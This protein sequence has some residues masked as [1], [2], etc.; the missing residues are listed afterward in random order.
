MPPGSSN[1][2]PIFRPKMSFPHPFSDLPLK[3]IS[4]FQSGGLTYFSLGK[5][6]SSYQEP[7]TLK[8]ISKSHITLTLFLIHLELKRKIRSCT[9][10][11]PWKT[12]PVIPDQNRQSLYNV[13]VFRS[14]G[15]RII[16]FSYLEAQY[17]SAPCDILCLRKRRKTLLYISTVNSNF[18]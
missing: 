1:P 16:P 3:Y 5:I 14:N 9:L 4:V 18:C 11:V 10:V 6:L 12:T 17:F 15:A 13:L 2:E 7:I 8:S